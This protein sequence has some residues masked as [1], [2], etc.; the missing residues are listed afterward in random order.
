M[1]LAYNYNGS[2]KD[3]EEHEVLFAR[4]AGRD[5]FRRKDKQAEGAKGHRRD[6]DDERDIPVKTA[7][8][9]AL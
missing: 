6:D 3:F 5:T 4:K 1:R 7:L 8:Y 2:L 9:H